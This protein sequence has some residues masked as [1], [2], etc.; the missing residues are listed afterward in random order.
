MPERPPALRAT[1]NR[2][3]VK[4]FDEDPVSLAHRKRISLSHDMI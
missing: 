3:G 2:Q 4:E 1:L